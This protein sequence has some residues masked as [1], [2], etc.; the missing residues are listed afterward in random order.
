MYI[1]FLVVFSV[2][3]TG[4]HL[5]IWQRL[6]Y[7]VTPPGLPRYIGTGIIIL[8]GLSAILSFILSRYLPLK[9]QEPLAYVA[10]TW[11]GMLVFITITLLAIDIISLALTYLAHINLGTYSY[12]PLLRAALSVLIATISCAIAMDEAVG[13]PQITKYDIHLPDLPNDFE[14]F[15]IAQ[16][17]DLHIAAVLNHKWLEKRVSETMALKPDM[18]AIT[19]DLTDGMPHLIKNELLP[20]KD[21]KAPYGTFFVPGN[22]EYI[23]DA[24][25]WLKFLP[26]VGLKVLF[27]EHIAI[28]K[29]EA[30]IYLAGVDDL[31]AARYSGHGPDLARATAGI[32]GSAIVIGLAHQPNIADEAQNYGIDLLL[33]GHT[34]GGQ[35]WPWTIFV[36]SVQK[37]FKGFYRVGHTQ[38]LVSQGTGFWGP[39]MRMGS[40]SEI[41]LITLHK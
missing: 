8:L 23:S 20:L 39:P 41:L 21:L 25:G 24:D 31:S 19:G 15:T 38:L 27:N 18:V 30:V 35:L 10:Y 16:L 13:E 29:G 32:P 40:Q 1:L 5:Y 7:S 3:V 22:H 11:M 36:K 4:V 33:T 26:E 37:Y 6:V 28:S 9:R 34:H 2:M 14:G 17:S 12:W